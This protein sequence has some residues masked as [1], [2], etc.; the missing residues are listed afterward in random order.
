MNVQAPAERGFTVGEVFED[1]PFTREHVKAC[2]CLFFTFVIEAW[3]AMV[4]VYS[5]DS[6]RH[7]LRIGP[8]ALGNL[9]GAIFIG[10]ALGAVFWGRLSNRIGRK[11]SVI[12]SLSLY[13]VISMISA[14]APDYG[15][16]YAL[17]L[18]AGLAVV[19][20]MVVTFPYFEELLPVRLRGAATVFLSA[21]W[22]L[23]ILVALAVCQVWM[24]HGWR[25]IIAVSSLGGLWAL[26]IWRLVPESP[27]W[28]AAVG[29][30][31]DARAVLQRLGGAGVVLPPAAQ[32]RVEPVERTGVWEVLRGSHFQLTALQC[33][34]NFA[35][36][37]GYW[38]LQTWLPTLL[39]ERGLDLPTSYGFIAL[40]AFFMIPGYL[41]AAWATHRFGRKWVMVTYVGLSTMAGFAFAA[42]PNL[43]VLYASNF[44][45]VFFSQGAWGV[46]NTWMCEFYDTRLRTLGYSW[47]IVAQRL[48][49]ILA[50]IAIG[51]LVASGAGFMTI[52]TFINLFM[53]ASVV[54]ALLLPETEGRR[55]A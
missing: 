54:M 4:I 51:F 3:E 16:L 42:S 28:L 8:V 6:I 21:G 10:M 2:L 39:Q 22:P 50:P 7:D 46:W 44:A 9:I 26:L 31:E 55:L 18:L 5:S 53:V 41:S 37:W 49:N 33:M 32:L 11:R 48:S 12:W 20:I 1:F 15:S 38:G 43:P 19:G 23:G 27:Y 17:R 52:T 36:A 13:G 40:S 45:M 30:R 24:A 14:F 34:L 29:R 25:W 35:F 47:G